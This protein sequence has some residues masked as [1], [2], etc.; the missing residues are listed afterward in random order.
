MIRDWARLINEG[1]DFARV[2]FDLSKAFDKMNH[3]FLASKLY[4]H[5]VAPETCAWIRNNL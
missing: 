3:E 2:Y 4:F 1:H 5:V